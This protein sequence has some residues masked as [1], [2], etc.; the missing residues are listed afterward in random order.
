MRWGKL[1]LLHALLGFSCGVLALPVAVSPA[2]VVDAPK[3]DTLSGNLS[4]VGSDTLANL[5]SLWADDFNHH[6][7][8]VNLQIQAAGSSTAP[9]ALAAGAAQL[10][11]MSRPMKA[12]EITAFT[13]RYGYPPLA[14]PVAVDALVVFVHQDNPLDKLT[15]SQLDAVFSQNRRCGESH[16]IQRFGEL[17]LKEHWAERSIQRYSR[18]SASG[19]YGFFKQ[20]VL[21]GGD[22]LNN[23]NELPG[24]ASVVQAVAGSLNG[25][26]YASIGFRNSGV[27]PLSLSANGQDYVMPTAEN[28]KDGRYPL[29]R[30]LY[31][32]INKAPGKP[33]EP[34]TAAF[35]ERVLSPEGQKRVTHDG[36]LPLPPEILNHTRKEL[37]FAY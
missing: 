28:V 12:A 36:Y 16:R 18:N 11:P 13:E 23:I 37:G 8:G 22:F 20:L 15:L 14:V 7:P 29:S 21:C 30:Y 3:P 19:T 5:M 9:A 34:L 25:M 32:Y 4:S 31:I 24:S 26:G 17:G 2:T 1:A 33:L 35:L 27:K 10:G 6:Y